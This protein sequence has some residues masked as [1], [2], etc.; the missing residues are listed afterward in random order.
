MCLTHSRAR[1]NKIIHV[2]LRANVSL[3]TALKYYRRDSLFIG[4]LALKFR[5]LLKFYAP[6]RRAV[7]TDRGY[8]QY[9]SV[10]ARSSTYYAQ[11]RVIGGEKCVRVEITFATRRKSYKSRNSIS[12][13]MTTT[14]TKQLPQCYFVYSK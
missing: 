4:Q 7:K 5:H 8:M 2:S 3:F 13:T 1:N 11:S 12:T 9:L 6:R 10:V 14:A